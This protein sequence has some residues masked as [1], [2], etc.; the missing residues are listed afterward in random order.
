[1]LLESFVRD[2]PVGADGKSHS[3]QHAHILM[4]M[5]VMHWYGHGVDQSDE[6]AKGCFKQ[7]ADLL[8]DPNSLA[9]GLALYCEK[10]YEEAHSI[11]LRHAQEGNH[12][13]AQYCMG[14]MYYRGRGVQKNY[15]QAMEWYLK[16]AKQGNVGA[17]HMVGSM[18][19]REEGVDR[20]Y[21][22]A[23][24]WYLQAANQGHRDAQ[25]GVYTLQREQH[26]VQQVM[27]VIRVAA[28]QGN[29]F[30]Q[31]QLGV[32]FHLGRGGVG[33]DS[34]QAMEWYQM[35]A[36]QGNQTAR[37]MLEHPQL[38]D[39]M[40]FGGSDEMGIE[41]WCQWIA[42]VRSCDPEL[43]SI[44]LQWKAIGDA[45]FRDL[46]RAFSESKNAVVKEVRLRRNSLTSAS[47]KVVGPVIASL[48]KLDLGG[49][50]L[51][52]DGARLLTESLKVC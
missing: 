52:P 41:E 5:G 21:K 40:E 43:V 1:M 46:S 8:Q 38:V 23:M 36:V 27:D 25:S 35:A 19:E 32:C 22:Q 47:M 24:E 37:F 18:F 51:G 20:D 14:D 2:H 17:Q 33:R 48:T 6:K 26:H 30:A 50:D 7:A 12:P 10:K 3:E 4:E 31:L 15:K 39:E 13:A 34:K 44:D 42:R 45:G 28:E 11:V 9:S 29:A 49:N 16:A